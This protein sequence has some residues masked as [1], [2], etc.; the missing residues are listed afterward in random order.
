MSGK[1]CKRC[2]EE[3]ER[4]KFGKDKSKADGLTYAC[5]HCTSAYKLAYDQSQNRRVIA[6]EDRPKFDMAVKLEKNRAYRAANPEKVRLIVRNY[7]R[8]NPHVINAL[9]SARRAASLAAMPSWADK[10]RIKKLYEIAAKVS[11]A[12]GVKHHVDHVFPLIS[13]LVCGLHVPENMRVIAA[14]ANLAKSNTFLD[15]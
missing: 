11:R 14:Q 7:K 1:L 4:D 15:H 12:T 8:K 13:P 10:Q 3:K 5:K 6:K 9:V 2:G